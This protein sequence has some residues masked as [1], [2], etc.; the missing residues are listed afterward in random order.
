MEESKVKLENLCK[1]MKEILDKEVIKKAPE[2][3]P[4]HSVVESLWQKAEV[5]KNDN[6][7]KDHVVLLFEAVLL[8]FGFSLEFPQTHSNHIY[9]MIQP[10]AGTD[11]SEVT[12]E[13]PRAAIPN[14]RPSLSMMR[15]PLTG[16]K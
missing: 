5:D 6:A 7:V 10:G 3:Q 9:L 11:D 1:F 13:G 14:E 15:M 4:F 2:D 16:K 8:S 12:A